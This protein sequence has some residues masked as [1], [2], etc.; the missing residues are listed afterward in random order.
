MVERLESLGYCLLFYLHCFLVCCYGLQ[1]PFQ[2]IS[3]WNT[4]S[5]TEFL[6]WSK[7]LSY[8]DNRTIKNSRCKNRSDNTTIKNSRC[9]NRSD[10]TTIKNS[11]CKNRSDN[12]T[13]KNSRCKNRSVIDPVIHH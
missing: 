13:I 1:K 5:R 7:R 6:D 4:T 12:R 9:K 8:Q 11:R 3:I 10:N 2:T